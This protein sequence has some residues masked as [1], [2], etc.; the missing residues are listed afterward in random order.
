MALNLILITDE[1]SHEFE[2]TNEFSLVVDLSIARPPTARTGPTCE[3][4]VQG[5]SSKI[6]SFWK[7][8]CGRCP[9]RGFTT[10]FSPLTM[11]VRDWRLNSRR[12]ASSFVWIK[13]K[14][15]WLKLMVVVW[16]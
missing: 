3:F 16:I 1:L 6:N 12:G 8:G 14:T 2:L 9:L 13:S 5:P 7:E 11:V 10:N 4:E 15:H